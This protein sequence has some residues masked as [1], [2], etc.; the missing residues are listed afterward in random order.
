MN[1]TKGF[2]INS[3]NHQPAAS[4]IN[5]EETLQSVFEA[6]GRN[7]HEPVGA[8]AESIAQKQV[9][10]PYS[11]SAPSWEC[12]FLSPTLISLLFYSALHIS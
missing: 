10:E 11:S 2:W 12:L 1:G 3:V 6:A 9:C 7:A 8:T 5:D 4:E